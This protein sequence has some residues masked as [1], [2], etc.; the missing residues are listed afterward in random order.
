MKPSR[1]SREALEELF[2]AA[3]RYESKQPG[4]ADRFLEDIE[5]HL[6]LIREL[7]A[8]FPVLHA[9]PPGLKIRRA[10]LHTFPYALVFLELETELRIIAVAHH[11]RR[12]NYWL[13]RVRG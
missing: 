7:P 1:L 10:L 12:P 6:T 5:Q 9:S 13:S 8:A 11:K 3:E 2:E 4:L